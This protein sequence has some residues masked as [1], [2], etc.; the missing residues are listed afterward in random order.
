MHRSYIVAIDK[1]TAYTNLDIEIGTIE[2]PIGQTY[3]EKV[4]ALY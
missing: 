3:K 2:I 4:K 1:I